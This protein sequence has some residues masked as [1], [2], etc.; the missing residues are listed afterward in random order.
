MPRR[1]WPAPLPAERHTTANL[2]KEH[3]MNHELERFLTIHDGMARATNRWIDKTPADK[4]D[5]IPFDNPNMKFGDRISTITIRS[6]Y[7]HTIVAEDGWSRMLRDCADG[8]AFDPT[9]NPALTERLMTG[10]DL[11]GEAMK[12]HDANMAVFAGFDDERLARRISW[13]EREWS[14]MGFLWA[15]YS[16]RAYHLGN[17]DIYLREADAPAPDFFSAFP[18]VMA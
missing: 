11:V 16:H 10:S 3:D 13:V 6:L 17:L 7:V 12:L 9:P 5:W 18:A 4:L 1:C 14:I 2:A 15:I 8:D